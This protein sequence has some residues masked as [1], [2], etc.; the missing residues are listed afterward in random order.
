MMESPSWRN[1]LYGKIT[2][3]Q[4]AD[5]L[6]ALSGYWAQRA[7]YL[8][9]DDPEEALARIGRLT[10]VP[11][12]T[13]FYSHSLMEMLVMFV[14][15][16]G[17][18]EAIRQASTSADPFTAVLHAIDAVPDEPPDDP[19]ALALAMAFIA[20][21]EAIARYSRTI[22]DM[23]A[24][25]RERGDLQVLGQALSIDSAI[26]GLPF[27]QAMLKYGQLTGDPSFADELLG[28]AKGPHKRRLVYPSL[29]W[30][31]YLLRDRGA[32]EA[33]SQDDIYEL[34][35]VHLK[36]YGDDAEH[37]DAKKSLFALFRKW[38]KEAGIQKSKFSWSAT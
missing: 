7:L 31:E 15:V 17:T 38:W 1:K 35:V 10:A 8:P 5:V 22:N 37:K 25:L 12:W 30:A 13:G 6:A 33:C 28:A 3:G 23:L 11:N 14:S 16:T 2:G 20:N 34:V 19:A 24:E 27:C 9:T 36:L 32:F 26:L 29:R 21:L 18:G 4:L